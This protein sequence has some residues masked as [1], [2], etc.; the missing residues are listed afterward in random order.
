MQLGAADI[1]N[2]AFW[3]SRVVRNN[4]LVHTADPLTSYIRHL[5]TVSTVVDKHNVPRVHPRDQALYGSDDPRMRCL[6]VSQDGDIPGR[7]VELADQNLAHVLDII[8]G[9]L[10]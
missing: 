7:E 5:G 4:C 8:E 1:E 9:A 10:K 3:I 6:V 2:L